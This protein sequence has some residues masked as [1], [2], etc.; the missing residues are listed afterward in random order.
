MM[1]FARC[2]GE[3]AE[4]SEKKEDEETLFTQGW[5]IK[6]SSPKVMIIMMHRWRHHHGDGEEDTF[7]QE[8][9]IL[10]LQQYSNLKH[11][12]VPTRRQG[13]V[14]RLYSATDAGK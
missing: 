12:Q 13:E 10:K 5:P 1:I 3:G 8:K 2:G 4:L 7:T 11:P 9:N 6:K 14:S